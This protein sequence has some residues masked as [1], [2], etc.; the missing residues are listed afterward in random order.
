MADCNTMGNIAGVASIIWGCAVQLMAAVS[1]G[2][3]MT[4]APTQAQL[5]YVTL[6]ICCRIHAYSFAPVQR[7]VLCA[8][9]PERYRRF[10][11]NSYTG[12]IAGHIRCHQHRV[13][14]SSS[15]SSSYSPLLT[16]Y[17]WLSLLLSPPRR[18]KHSEILALTHWVTLQIVRRASLLYAE[19][20]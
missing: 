18:P 3:N 12:T 7:R 11:R 8:S 6:L 17:A 19:F 5:L 13:P 4:F 16:G 15:C 9:R 1:I 2:S 10:D 20:Q 14:P